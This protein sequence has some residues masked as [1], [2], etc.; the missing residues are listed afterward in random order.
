MEFYSIINDPERL[1]NFSYAEFSSMF[2]VYYGIKA[3]T[4]DM[5]AYFIIYSIKNRDYAPIVINSSGNIECL[6]QME[7]AA[8]ASTLKYKGCYAVVNFGEISNSP[9]PGGELKHSA[10]FHARRYAI[11][12]YVCTRAFA[13][14]FVVK[15]FEN[16]NT[17][18]I[19]D[20]VWFGNN[21]AK[22]AQ[23]PVMV[24][25]LNAWPRFYAEATM[26]TPPTRMLNFGG[27]A[28][29]IGYKGKVEPLSA[30]RI[31][32]LRSKIEAD[33]FVKVIK[34][35]FHKYIGTA[36][37]SKYSAKS[38]DG[39][40]DAP[41]TR[42]RDYL[43]I[44]D[45]RTVEKPDA[46][47]GR[48]AIP[49][50]TNELIMEV[51]NGRTSGLAPIVPCG[52]GTKAYYDFWYLLGVNKT[53]PANKG[54]TAKRTTFP[55]ALSVDII[56]P[57]EL[58]V[59]AQKTIRP[60]IKEATY[61][62]WVD[63]GG[64]GN[65]PLNEL[66]SMLGVGSSNSCSSEQGFPNGLSAQSLAGMST[67]GDSINPMNSSMTESYAQGPFPPPPSQPSQP[68]LSSANFQQQPTSMA[69]QFQP[70]QAPQFQ[71]QQA[72]P[73]QNFGGMGDPSMQYANAGGNYGGQF[74]PQA[75]YQ[76][77]MTQNAF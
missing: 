12:M 65:T 58:Y 28:A 33:G 52:T 10:D 16:P 41:S 50:W 18:G 21:Q 61:K 72:A 68:S 76:N 64:E 24:N 46:G 31:K 67:F 77:P 47:R 4:N 11:T 1:A 74:Q 17:M 34:D 56:A 71:P 7:G 66:A 39:K 25:Y 75:G 36:N 40:G 70:Q 20:M 60:V 42:L 48:V 73:Q 3:S 54:Q 35:S 38:T 59:G 27:I 62:A 30:D 57:L 5:R 69:P 32:S 49:N 15:H 6:S 8:A 43:P 14:D 22:A 55:R 13:N 63:V 29:S 53:N 23:D 19:F 9:V 26:D 37:I 44:E 2:Q 45:F 51:S